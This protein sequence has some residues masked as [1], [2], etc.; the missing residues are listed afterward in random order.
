M[1][2][3]RRRVPSSA[4]VTTRVL[5]IQGCYYCHNKH[6]EEFGTLARS[7]YHRNKCP[8]F[9]HHIAVGTCH[10]NDIGELCLG[11]KLA[12]RQAIP[13]PFWDSSISQGEQIKLCTD[14]TE[15]DEVMEKRARNPVVFRHWAVSWLFHFLTFCRRFLKLTKSFDY[16]VR[17]VLSF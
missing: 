15:F 11:P 12:G 7:H 2:P 8:W 5:I 1:R 10:L 4:P 14:D 17:L 3:Q 6:G 16:V 13:L 9:E